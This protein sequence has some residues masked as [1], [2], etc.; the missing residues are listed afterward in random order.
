M[1]PGGSPGGVQS[2]NPPRSSLSS[3]MRSPRGSIEDL[4]SAERNIP[5]FHEKH[6]EEVSPG[7]QQALKTAQKGYARI[8]PSSAAAEAVYGPMF[9]APLGNVRKR[10]ADGLSWKDRLILDLK[11]IQ[12][13]KWL[14]LWERVVLPRSIDHARDMAQLSSPSSSSVPSPGLVSSA[15]PPPNT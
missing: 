5:S 12:A 6:G 7:L 3:L 2:S 13:N 14:E 1:A 9:P 15:V 10:K 11:F 4:V 8:F